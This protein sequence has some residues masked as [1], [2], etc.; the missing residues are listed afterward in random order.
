MSL[1]ILR[2]SIS[3]EHSVAF[4]WTEVLVEAISNDF[5]RP[6]VHSRNLFHVSAA[7]YDAWAVIDGSA[8]PYF[9]E[10]QHGD[11]VFEFD[12]FPTENIDIKEAQEEAMSYAAYRLILYRFRFA[13]DVAEIFTSVNN[14]FQELGY[15]PEMFSTD[16]S[17]GS[18]AALGN[19]I[20]EQVI[21]FGLTDGSN[22]VNLYE[23][24]YYFPSNNAFSPEGFG[25]TSLFD[26]NRWQ[27]LS[28]TRIVDQAGFE[29]LGQINEFLSPEWGEVIPFALSEEDLTVYNRDGFDYNVYYDPGPPPYYEDDFDDPLNNYRW[30]FAM[31]PVWGSHLDPGDSVRI[32]ISPA[33]IGNNPPLP[34]SF[35]DFEDFYD[36]FE[37]GDAS[38]GHDVNPKT[39]EP[40]EENIVLRGDFGRVLAEFWADGIDSETPPGHWFVIL[41][42]VMQH[43]EFV[44]KFEGQGEELDALEYDVKAYF[45][46]GGAMHDAAVAAWSIKGWYDYVRPISAIRAM[47]ELGQCS[48]STLA[49]YHPGGLPLIEGYIELITEEDHNPP[50][51][52]TFRIVRRGTERFGLL[53]QLK[54]KSWVGPDYVTNSETD[55]G[56]VQWIPAGE[57][58]PYQRP[59][60]VTPPFAGYVSG[61]STFSR[62]AAEVLTMLTGDPFFPGGI[63][64]FV[65]KKDEY[66]VFED[67]PSEDIVLQWATYRDASDQTSLSRIWGGIHPPA[68]DIPGRLIGEQIGIDAFLKASSFFNTSSTEA[69]QIEDLDAINLFPNPVHQGELIQLNYDDSFRNARIQITDLNGKVVLTDSLNEL[70]VFHVDT[71]NIASGTYILAVQSNDIYATSKVVVMNK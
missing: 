67:G 69:V 16:Y 36:F 61:H 39:G 51:I 49:N 40:Y 50:Y 27:P 12:G 13:P 22:E 18:P 32:D 26:F 71:S 6:T 11:Y 46:L 59:T 28:L 44:R 54:I 3:Q 8:L 56:G 66:L 17:S 35:D 4:Q 21:Q 60:F 62:A 24:N 25:N 5:A 70:N 15:D 45:T 52:D 14:L 23:N 2:V 20:A 47:A 48:D 31:V 55:I 42:T 41:N 7:M 57:W 30:G 68:D 33:S 38:R 63:G 53:G 19:Y 34:T 29:I 43:P 65:A 1:T 9:L 58:W 64:E 10:N 37:G